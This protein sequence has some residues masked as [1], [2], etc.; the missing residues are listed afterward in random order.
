MRIEKVMI[1]LGAKESEKQ[2]GVGGGGGL[3]HEDRKGDDSIRFKKSK[4]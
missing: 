3:P 4:R 1:Q 2:P